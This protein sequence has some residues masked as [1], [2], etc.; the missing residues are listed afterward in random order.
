SRRIRGRSAPPS[1]ALQRRAAA[2]PDQSSQRDPVTY[3]EQRNSSPPGVDAVQEPIR[4]R[5]PDR[6]GDARLTKG[7]EVTDRPLES[8]ASGPG[9]GLGSGGERPPQPVRPAADD[10]H[11][12]IPPARRSEPS[13]PPLPDQR[14][15]D[16]VRERGA[17]SSGD[18]GH[19]V[20][21]ARIAGGRY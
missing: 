11:P 2:V 15:G 18:D 21:G 10:F 13:G 5:P 3:P 8:A 20:P 17:D 16:V 7:P 9:S 1:G 12:D 4:R 6:A 19:L 14:N